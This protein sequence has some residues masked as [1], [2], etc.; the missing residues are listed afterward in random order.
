MKRNHSCSIVTLVHNSLLLAN[1]IM[2]SPEL[3]TDGEMVE[4][5]TQTE[6]KKKKP[7]KTYPKK[8]H[9]DNEP[10]RPPVVVYDKRMQALNLN[11]RNDKPAKSKEYQ[12]VRHL[13]QDSRRDWVNGFNRRMY[14][15]KTVTNDDTMLVVRSEEKNTGNFYTTSGELTY[16]GGAFSFASPMQTVPIS[17]GPSVNSTPAQTPSITTADPDTSL[18]INFVQIFEW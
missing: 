15:F 6:T 11:F 2:Q 13:R 4:V 9:I 8:I 17:P 3:E 12:K 7:R 1:H 16:R 5:Q 14:S 18:S 10:E